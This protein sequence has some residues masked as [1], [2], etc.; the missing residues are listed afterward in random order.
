M[1]S[2]GNRSGYGLENHGFYNNRNIYWNYSPAK[3]IEEGLR[4]NEVLLSA[5]GVVIASTGTHTGRSPN[6]R[7]VVN[8]DNENSEDIWWGPVNQPID[9]HYFDQ[10]LQKLLAFF[11]NR[12]LFVQ[13][14]V[15]GTHPDYQLPIRIITEKAWHNLFARN[16]FLHSPHSNSTDYIPEFT[17]IHSE[18]FQAFPPTD[19]TRTGTFILLDFEKRMVLIG[20]TGYAGEIKKSVFA[21]MNYL[22]PRQNILSMHSSANLGMKGDVALFFGLSGTGKTTLSSAPQRRLIGDDEHGW[23]EDGVFNIEGGCYAK[24]IRLNQKLEP[25]IWEATHHFGSILENVDFDTETHIVNFDSDKWTENTR[26]AYPLSFIPDHVQEGRAGHPD[27]IFFL[28]ADAFGVMPPIAKLTHQ[29]ALYYFLSGYTSKV[30]GTETDLGK[31]P[32]ATFSTCFGAPFLPLHPYR[33]AELLGENITRHKVTVWLINTGW[34]GGP[35][36]KGSRISLPY[37]RAMIN[38]VLDHK[39]D[40]VSLWQDDYFRLFIP[41]HCPGVP[42]EILNP[43]K[44][45]EDPDAYHRSAQSLITRFEENFSQYTSTMPPTLLQTSPQNS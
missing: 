26:A 31:E 44:T 34:T 16:L 7:F 3:L 8:Y 38:A 37:T 9:P 33:Y 24:T 14:L 13:D 20:G 35:Y 1:Q 32:Q 30:A 5:S 21:I 19:G 41:E 23:C 39:L 2:F 17:V 42:T 25:L 22:L 36:G 4:R 10:L 12:D 18:S 6:D 45:W 29:Q 11:Q 40:D 15:A 28:T 27:H 43:K